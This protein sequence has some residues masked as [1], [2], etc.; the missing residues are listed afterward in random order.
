MCHTASPVACV[1]AWLSPA[2]EESGRS[3]QNLI[4]ST[5]QF[6]GRSPQPPE[7]TGSWRLAAIRGARLAYAETTS[8]NLCRNT[9]MCQRSCG[10]TTEVRFH[11][12]ISEIPAAASNNLSRA[13]EL[14]RFQEYSESQNILAKPRNVC[15]NPRSTNSAAAPWKRRRGSVITH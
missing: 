4:A 9:R 13:A 5:T 14:K 15:R 6:L 11:R 7:H 10:S 8:V 12:S 1:Y 3:Y 2:L